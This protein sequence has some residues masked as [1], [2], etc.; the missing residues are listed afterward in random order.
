MAWLTPVAT[1]WL[2]GVKWNGLISQ[3]MSTT[4]VIL[5]SSFLT[6]TLS[7]PSHSCSLLTARARWTFYLLF[8]MVFDDEWC[9]IIFKKKPNV[10]NANQHSTIIHTNEIAKWTKIKSLLQLNP[11][12]CSFVLYIFVTVSLF[13]CLA[14]LPIQILIN[15]GHRDSIPS[16][17]TVAPAVASLLS[18][19]TYIRCVCWNHFVSSTTSVSLFF[20]LS[21]S[22]RFLL[23]V[24]I[25]WFHQ[26]ISVWI[27]GINSVRSALFNDIQKS[28]CTSLLYGTRFFYF[29]FILFGKCCIFFSFLFIT[30]TLPLFWRKR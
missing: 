5:F 27:P 7:A 6:L 4:F 16:T 29:D 24:R 2:S 3:V 14:E 9:H 25:N 10:S 20:H 21:P 19:L 26:R 18:L 13:L 22:F 1:L 15:Y 11:F 30:H 17:S 28:M 12:Q 23:C 8:A